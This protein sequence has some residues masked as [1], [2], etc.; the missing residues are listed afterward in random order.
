MW[1]GIQRDYLSTALAWAANKQLTTILSKGF[2]F[3]VALNHGTDGLDQ[4]AA[5]VKP[6]VQPPSNGGDDATPSQRH[7]LWPPR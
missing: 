2:L 1:D 5:H 3:D 7:R 4:I 6:G